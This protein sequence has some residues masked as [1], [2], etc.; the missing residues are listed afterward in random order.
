MIFTTIAMRLINIITEQAIE[1]K[2]HLPEGM[3]QQV[4]ID[5]RRQKYTLADKV[6]IEKKIVEKSNNNPPH[7]LLCHKVCQ[8]KKHCRLLFSRATPQLSN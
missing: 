2:K 6:D 1:R 4:C 7:F 3:V 5:L 8:S